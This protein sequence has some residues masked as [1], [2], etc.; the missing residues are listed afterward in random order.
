MKTLFSR[1]GS[2]KD[3]FHADISLVK[4][5]YTFPQPVMKNKVSSL[6]EGNYDEKIRVAL[7]KN[8]SLKKEV[9]ALEQRINAQNE[10]KKKLNSNS[11]TQ[12]LL[13]A[14]A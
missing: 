10:A 11:K 7:G 6:E 13:D 5:N 12:K 1:Q 8:A 3:S 2:I 9:E 4:I 14:F